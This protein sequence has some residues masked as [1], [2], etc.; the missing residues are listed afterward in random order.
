MVH[1]G[2]RTADD[3]NIIPVECQPSLG[4]IL[5]SITPT[6]AVIKPYTTSLYRNIVYL[7]PRKESEHLHGYS[8]CD[9]MSSLTTMTSQALRGS[10]ITARKNNRSRALQVKA[11]AGT[12]RFFVGGAHCAQWL[13]VLDK[14][15]SISCT[16]VR[17]YLADLQPYKHTDINCVIYMPSDGSSSNV[18]HH[19]ALVVMS[20]LVQEIGNAMGQSNL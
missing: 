17:V 12:G 6:H 13:N 2:R 19:R 5:E 7:F 4:W 20:C 15:T 16:P 3:C 1:K 18:A 14:V 10:G 9:D 8:W 11:M